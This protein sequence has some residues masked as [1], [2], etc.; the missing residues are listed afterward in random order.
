M[1]I[2]FTTQYAW[3]FRLKP[4]VARPVL[5]YLWG[6]GVDANPPCSDAP[7]A[8]LAVYADGIDILI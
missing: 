1:L 4:Q 6:P 2:I 3:V 5:A 7:G 8:L